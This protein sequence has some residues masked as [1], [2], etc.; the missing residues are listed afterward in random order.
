MLKTR[1]IS[2]LI[3]REGQ[4][5][6]S[7]RFKH[8]NVIHYDAI[9]AVEAFNKWA[10]DEIVL[11]NVDREPA[12][13]E[14]FADCLARISRQCFV[15][16][17]AGGWIT[18]DDYAQHLLRSGADKLV[19]NSALFSDPDLIVRLSELYGRQCIVVS[20]D[21]KRKEDGSI[22]V[23][24][25]RGRMWQDSSPENSAKRAEELG[26]GEILF[27]SIDH[28]GARKGYDLETLGRI[29]QG[30]QIPVVAFGGVFTWDHMVEGV[31]AGAN[32]V[33]AANKFHYTEQSARKAKR[34]LAAANVPVRGFHAVSEILSN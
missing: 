11:L 30:V 6:Q 31:R 15:P 16:I 9:H 1:L 22:G 10:I 29:C 4:V 26:A 32:A 33:A 18:D 19:L 21:A 13:R 8:T 34:H 28:D 27:N 12:G 17:A 3:L 25:D 14:V 7:V 20:I 24:T 23:M 5:V 2:V